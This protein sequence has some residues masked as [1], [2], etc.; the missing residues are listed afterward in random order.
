MPSDKIIHAAAEVPGLLELGFQH[1]FDEAY[2]TLEQPQ[3]SPAAK[4]GTETTAITAEKPLPAGFPSVVIESG[5]IAQRDGS[6][7]NGTDS[8]AKSGRQADKIDGTASSAVKDLPPPKETPILDQKFPVRV[9]P[10]SP[11]ALVEAALPIRRISLP[12]GDQSVS[13]EVEAARKAE[14]D[15]NIAEAIK[16]LEAHQ[17]NITSDSRYSDHYSTQLDRALL[18][19]C[20]ELGRL[21]DKARNGPEARTQY[22]IAIKTYKKQHTWNARNESEL[23]RQV[24]FLQLKIAA[25]F[26]AQGN[27]DKAIEAQQEA[28]KVARKGEVPYFVS[29]ND[30]VQME[31]RNALA[32]TLA[33]RGNYDEAIKEYE[34]TIKLLQKEAGYSK[35]FW[36]PQDRDIIATQRKM[37]DVYQKAGKSEEAFK[38]H[39]ENLEIIERQ[40]RSRAKSATEWDQEYYSAKRGQATIRASQGKLDEALALH[41]E[42]ARMLENKYWS[43]SYR[44]APGDNLSKR[45]SGNW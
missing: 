15:G 32:A 28:L 5:Q 43:S 17:I 29:K 11:E 21:H 39:Q 34:Q 2:K 7:L 30:P 9:L 12:G 10:K 31:C 14:M 22:D 27:L 20:L 37:A 36:C 24:V 40:P 18:T 45:A 4:P 25:S 41:G 19:S 8:V 23:D 38:L 44:L 3:P 42:N 16:I 35:Y 33:N 6:F 13:Q 26:E 1:V